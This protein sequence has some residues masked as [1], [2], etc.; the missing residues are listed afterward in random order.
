MDDMAGL[1]DNSKLYKACWKRTSTGKKKVTKVN[2]LH[3]ESLIASSGL[4]NHKDAIETFQNSCKNGYVGHYRTLRLWQPRK[5]IG[6]T[7]QRRGDCVRFLQRRICNDLS[8]LSTITLDALVSF[9]LCL[10]K[11]SLPGKQNYT[12]G[13]LRLAKASEIKAYL[14]E[15]KS[16][17]ENFINLPAA[18]GIN[19]IRLPKG[20]SSNL[21]QLKELYWRKC[22]EMLSSD[23]RIDSSLDAKLK[24]FY[25]SCLE[26]SKIDRMGLDHIINEV[27]FKGGWPRMTNKR[28]YESNYDWL[29][30]CEMRRNLGVDI[31]IGLQVVPDFTDKDMHRIMVGAPKLPLSQH[32]YYWMIGRMNV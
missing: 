30:W 9:S 22:G 16:P 2:V 27:D 5:T 20:K 13:L 24:N 8:E 1:Y 3:I 21:D 29:R 10:H 12:E 31:M 11:E 17:C 7:L 25:E 4:G 19:C 32:A 18:S 6:F 28:W 15:E 14:N 26:T 23:A